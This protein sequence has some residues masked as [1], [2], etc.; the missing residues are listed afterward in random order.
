M[1]L[2]THNCL[3]MEI[4]LEKELNERRNGGDLDDDGDDAREFGDTMREVELERSRFSLG[5]YGIEQSGE[6]GANSVF[7][8][9]GGTMDPYEVKV[10]KPPYGW[11]NPAPNTAKGGG[12]LR[13][14]G[15]LRRTE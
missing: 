9:V 10:P 1:H 5:D 14:S 3:I 6:W 12:Y 2:P 4:D 13:Q 8:H 7:L 11:V 15:Q